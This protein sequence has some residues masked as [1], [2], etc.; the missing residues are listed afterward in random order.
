MGFSLLEL[1]GQYQS[2]Q[3]P[4]LQFRR[5]RLRPLPRPWPHQSHRFII[6]SFISIIPFS[7]LKSIHDFHIIAEGSLSDSLEALPL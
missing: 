4:C 5:F 6:S 1:S 7:F 3:G 2:H